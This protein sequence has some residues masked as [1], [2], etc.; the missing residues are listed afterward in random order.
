VNRLSYGQLLDFELTFVRSRTYYSEWFQYF[1]GSG[2]L[3]PKLRDPWAHAAGDQSVTDVTVDEFGYSQ[4]VPNITPDELQRFISGK[5]LFEADFA[6]HV[7]YNPP[8]TFDCPRGATPG[9]KVATIVTAPGP[10][11]L[12]MDGNAYS[13]PALAATSRTRS[14]SKAS[15][16]LSAR[17]AARA[18]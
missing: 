7:G 17:V 11:P 10:S 9:S 12:F 18:T 3:Q 13:N 14:H 16:C 4:H 5:V 15:S 1:V 8:T 2:R 6:T